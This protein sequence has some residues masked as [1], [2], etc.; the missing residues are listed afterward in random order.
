[1]SSVDRHSLSLSP[2]RN[3]TYYFYILCR[4]LSH[5]QFMTATGILQLESTDFCCW[6]DRIMRSHVNTHRAISCCLGQIS[7]SGHSW[8]HPGSNICPNP[9]LIV[10]AAS[11]PSLA[12]FLIRWSSVESFGTVPRPCLEEDGWLACNVASGIGT[13]VSVHLN[14]MCISLLATWCYTSPELRSISW[15]RKVLP[16]SGWG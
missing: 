7:E 9:E 4:P 5:S 6:N 14:T 12:A 11:P 13:Y 1:M 10:Q 16:K 2:E 15:C 3:F 8:L